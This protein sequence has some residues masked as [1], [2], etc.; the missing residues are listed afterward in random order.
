MRAEER[1]ADREARDVA[2]RDRDRRP[3]GHRARAGGAEDVVVAEDVVGQPGRVGGQREDRVELVLDRRRLDRGHRQPVGGAAQL[4][5]D[6]VGQVAAG[7]L[8][9]V[10]D[11][12]AEPGEHP[13]GVP[14]VELDQLG[15]R[16]RRRLLGVDREFG[17]VLEIGVDPVLELVVQR[18]ELG[19]GDLL[20]AGQLDRVDHHRAERPQAAH[21]DV[22]QRGG[23]GVGADRGGPPDADPR[24]LE[25][26]RVEER[27]VVDAAVG[28]VGM[29]VVGDA[30]D[31]EIVRV[32]GGHR[33]Q[34]DGRVGDRDRHR[35]RGVLRPGTAAR[36][37]SC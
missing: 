1:D 4:Q 33:G 25:R 15:Q 26:R 22:E 9:R 27:G 11:L 16:R 17:Q 32:G 24:P 7:R 6:R 31:G 21:G 12:L 19:L 3:A 36:C 13:V 10:E 28:P 14:L 20:D 34:Q 23:G 18:V 30:Q 37:R 2:E 35:A 29:V 5:V 8:G